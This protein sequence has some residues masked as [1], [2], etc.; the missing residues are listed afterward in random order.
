MRDR[1]GIVLCILIGSFCV[2][3]GQSVMTEMSHPGSSP[4]GGGTT[5]VGSAMGDGTCCSPPARE[6]PTVIFDDLVSPEPIAGHAGLCTWTTPVWDISGYRRVVIHTP[7]CKFAAQVRNGK[8][9][10][11]QGVVSQCEANDPL[12]RAT[13]VDATLGHDLRVN[14][15]WDSGSVVPD[16][17]FACGGQETPIPVT[18]VGYKNP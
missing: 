2:Y 6:Q 9:G 18:V 1:L 5:A 12:N 16:G 11:V 4:T 14:F 8:A 7:Y 3:C 10:F 13:T 17:D 15:M